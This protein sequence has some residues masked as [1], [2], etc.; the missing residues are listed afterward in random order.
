MAVRVC[1]VVCM[2]GGRGIDVW[3]MHVLLGESTGRVKFV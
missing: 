3:E 2:Y 1:M